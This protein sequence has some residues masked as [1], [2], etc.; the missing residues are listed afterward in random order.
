MGEMREQD[1]GDP[2]AVPGIGHREG[3]LRPPGAPADVGA[4][5]DDRA[6]RSPQRDQRQ[7]VV[8]GRGAARGR[9]EVDAGAEEA[10]PAR[11]APTA[12]SRNA[13]NRGTS[14]TVDGRT[15][16]VEPSRSTMSVSAAT[17]ADRAVLV[18]APKP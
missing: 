10:K 6:L 18:M 11:L 8:G 3:D 7:P 17:S 12:T 14:S 4:V 9:V 13:R 5:P 15:C 1:G 16:T 2:V